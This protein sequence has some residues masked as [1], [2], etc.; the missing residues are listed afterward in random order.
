MSDA[1][2]CTR[3]KAEVPSILYG[4][5]PPDRDV[6]WRNRIVMRRREVTHVL[7]FRMFRRRWLPEDPHDQLAETYTE[8]DLCD[9]CARAVFAFAQGADQ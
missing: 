1:K 3:C 4:P 7:R 6:W 9:S 5:P 2:T 8:L